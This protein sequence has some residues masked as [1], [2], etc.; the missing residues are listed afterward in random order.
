LPV[1]DSVLLEDSRK[2]GSWEE[3]VRGGHDTKMG[4]GTTKYS[5]SSVTAFYFF[6]FSF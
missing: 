6:S 4:L 5:F 3:E 2:E 1:L